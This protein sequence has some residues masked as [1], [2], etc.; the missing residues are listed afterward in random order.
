M[1]KHQPEEED[2]PMPAVSAA[3]DK[4]TLVPLGTEVRAST[5]KRLGYYL[6]DHPGEQ[7][8]YAVDQALDTWLRTHGYE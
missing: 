3:P 7:I 1:G 8:R 2:K 5:R 4:D 6:A